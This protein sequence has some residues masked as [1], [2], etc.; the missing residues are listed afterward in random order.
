M[1][2]N[3]AFCEMIITG[4]SKVLPRARGSSTCALKFHAASRV[5]FVFFLPI[6]PAVNMSNFILQ[7]FPSAST[8]DTNRQSF[9]IG[10]NPMAPV[11]YTVSAENFLG[12]ST[13]I[14]VQ[15][16]HSFV[17]L[18]FRLARKVLFTKHY[19]LACGYFRQK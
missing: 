14:A 11:K 17:Y 2:R 18:H 16:A 7:Y 15:F 6:L 13:I 9:F 5:I 1:C 12:V 8:Q 10:L 19:F 3:Y 4:V